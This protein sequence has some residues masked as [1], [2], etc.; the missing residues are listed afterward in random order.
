M[1]K[2]HLKSYAENGRENNDFKAKSKVIKV[3]EQ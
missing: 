2:F 3:V 1:S